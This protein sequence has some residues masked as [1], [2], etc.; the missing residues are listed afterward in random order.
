MFQSA[1]GIGGEQNKGLFIGACSRNGD[2]TPEVYALVGLLQ[3]PSQIH[4][5]VKI[6]FHDD[7]SVFQNTPASELYNIFPNMKRRRN[8]MSV[9]GAYAYIDYLPDS[10]V[11]YWLRFNRREN[12]LIMVAY[13]GYLDTFLCEFL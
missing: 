8:L 2:S 7:L 12:K 11:R 4:F 10:P 5:D 1:G 6:S 13:F 9:T 3:E